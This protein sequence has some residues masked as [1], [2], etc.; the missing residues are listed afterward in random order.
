MPQGNNLP[1]L[2]QSLLDDI[3]AR[4]GEDVATECLIGVSQKA[5]SLK[6]DLFNRSLLL[7]QLQEGEVRDV[8]RLS[9]LGLKYAGSWLSVVPSPALGLHLRPAEFV[10]MLRYIDLVFKCTQVKVCVLLVESQV[11]KWEITPS[12][13]LDEKIELLD[14]TY[15]EI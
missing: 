5:A 3:S 2:P 14:T 10:P 12:P 4:Q 7:N 13:V 11:T 1:N 15:C 9:S 6:V 8:A